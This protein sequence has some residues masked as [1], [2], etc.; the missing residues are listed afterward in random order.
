MKTL[1]II[2]LVLAVLIAIA[3]IFAGIVCVA[4][5]INGTTFSE[6][7]KLWL[8]AIGDFFKSPFVKQENKNE[9]QN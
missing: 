4:S 3:G 5:A 8:T 2:L 1:K 6:Q 7:L 9:R